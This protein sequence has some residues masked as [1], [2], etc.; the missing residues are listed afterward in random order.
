[1]SNRAED[2]LKQAEHDLEQAGILERA[3]G[4]G[5]ACFLSHQAA[6][7]AVKGLHLY[8]HQ[9]AWGHVIAHLLRE[10][11]ESIAVPESLH[12]KAHVLDGHYYPSR[13]PCCFPEGAP[14]DHYGGLQSGDA[15]QFAGEVVNFVRSEMA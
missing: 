8:R 1:M 15:A 4:H 12:E 13:Y 6:E 10:L 2:W 3:H 11:P 5:W 9:E 14:C 7:K